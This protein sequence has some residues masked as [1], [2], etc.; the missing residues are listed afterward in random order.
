MS[1]NP[2]FEI[3]SPDHFTADAIGP[4]GQRV[5]Y[6]QSRQSGRLVTLKVEKEHVRALGE[7][8][9][10]LLAR[11]KGAPSRAPGSVE[12]L[13]PVEAVWDVGSLAVGYDEGQD[14]VVVEASELQEETEEGAEEATTEETGTQ[15]AMA[16]FRITRG[17][18]AAFVERANELMKAGRPSC[19]LCSRPMDPEGHVC[20][21]S[22]GHVQ[23]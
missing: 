21:R 3:D 1:D 4:P 18:A 16:R 2:S 17:Q 8:L 6:L 20:P 22:N 9:T 7:Y 5:F 15:P 10:G 19:P 12:L 14:R 13:E 23:H 11:V